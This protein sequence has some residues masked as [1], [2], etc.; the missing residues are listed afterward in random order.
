MTDIL[1]INFKKFIDVDFTAQMENKLDEIE[2]GN[3]QWKSVVSEVY[4]PLKEAIEEAKEK[5]EKINM[6][7][8]TDEI[9][10]LCDRIW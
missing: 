1:N 7:E 2:D 6:D 3:I 8:E 9:C 10:E 5:I 4:E